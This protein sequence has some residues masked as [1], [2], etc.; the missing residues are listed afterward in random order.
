MHIMRKLILMLFICVG[1][2]VRAYAQEMI[3]Q[4]VIFK[5]DS[6]TVDESQFAMLEMMASYFKAH[7][8]EMFFIG[9]FTSKSTP[10]ERVDAVCEQRA[11]AVRTM[12]QDKYGVDCTHIFAIGVGVSTK[13]DMD[14]FNEK[15]EFFKK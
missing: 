15:V 9:G 2:A 14:E 5:K 3:G 6:V 8:K 11:Q 7:P 10:Q 12:L 13:A 4:R 1:F